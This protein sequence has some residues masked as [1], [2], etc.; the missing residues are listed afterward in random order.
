MSDELMRTELPPLPR[1]LQHLPVVR[2][3]PVPW[4]VAWIDGVPDFRISDRQKWHRAIR[5]RRCW[6]CGEALGVHLAFVIGPMCGINRTTTEPPCH[7]ACAVWSA[8]ACPFLARPHA[9]RRD[10]D[11][12]IEVH[13]PG[14]TPLLRNPGVTLIWITRTYRLFDDG[15]GNPLIEIGL[16]DAVQWWAEGRAA[17]REEVQRSVESGYPALLEVAEQQDAQQP[18]AGAVAELSRRALAFL[19]VYPRERAGADA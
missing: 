11:E 8:R 4:F 6:V 17:T 2:G 15:R 18:D 7:L 16:A 3:Y 1:R 14:G 12:A 5:E 9:R 19:S 10:V 13:Q